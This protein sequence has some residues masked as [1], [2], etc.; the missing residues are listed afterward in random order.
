MR[1]A[2]FAYYDTVVTYR[3]SGNIGGE[4]NL[5]VWRARL[6]SPNYV[7][8]LQARFGPPPNLNSANIFEC[9][10]WSQIAKF[11]AHQYY[12]L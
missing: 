9:P 1:Y 11:N 6:E 5:A 3:I 8:P 2:N 7:P 4:L 12:H 10:V